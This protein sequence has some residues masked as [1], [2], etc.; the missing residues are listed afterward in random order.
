MSNAR[1]CPDRRTVNW[2]ARQAVASRLCNLLFT[3]ITST[4]FVLA[5]SLAAQAAPAAS[6]GRLSGTVLNDSRQP[7]GGVEVVVIGTRLAGVT[8]A[9]GRYNIGGVP[10]G[11]QTVRAQRIGF[12]PSSQQV[13]IADGQL[14]TVDFQLTTAVTVLSEVVAVGYTNELRRDVSG[15]VS[16]VTGNEI[17]DQKVAT[18]EEA[19]RGRVPG[20][21]VSASGEPGRP[22]QIVIRGQRRRF[23]QQR[24]GYAAVAR[25]CGVVGE[26][27]FAVGAPGDFMD[28]IGGNALAHDDAARFVG[29]AES[30]KFEL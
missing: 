12:Q 27:G 2:H 9:D 7:I 24:D 1:S 8:A 20:V 18:L 23:A 11:P 4:L 14:T 15:A 13:A 28:A 3:I 10:V 30:S 22:A 25:E 19:I 5:P 16:S 17:K 21:Q 6:S 29:A 26:H